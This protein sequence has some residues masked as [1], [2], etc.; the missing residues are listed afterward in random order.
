MTDFARCL[1]IDKS[2]SGSSG[3]VF[4][5]VFNG[6]LFF[7]ATENCF[8]IQATF[9]LATPMAS[10]CRGISYPHAATQLTGGDVV[11]IAESVECMVDSLFA[12]TANLALAGRV[13]G[14]PSL[15]LADFEG[16][17]QRCRTGSFGS[18]C[19]PPQFLALLQTS[20]LILCNQVSSLPSVFHCCP[21]ESR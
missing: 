15:A 8:P 12:F 21:A 3:A 17:I 13:P 19:L 18:A 20:G 9:V 2:S 1:R 10:I 7:F 4:V 14:I 5:V 16:T 11:E 6:A